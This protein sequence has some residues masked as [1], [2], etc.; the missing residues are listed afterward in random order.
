MPRIPP[1]EVLPTE[2]EEMDRK[3]KERVSLLLYHL[4]K[5]GY[6]DGADGLDPELSGLSIFWVVVLPSVVFNTQFS[7]E[8]EKI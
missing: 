2:E 5:M 6:S 4:V 7:E 1:G 3:G 8:E